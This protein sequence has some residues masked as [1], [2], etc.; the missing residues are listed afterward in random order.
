MT[1]SSPSLVTGLTTSQAISSMFPGPSTPNASLL[2]N[3]LPSMS[4]SEVHYLAAG[5]Y[6]GEGLLTVPAKLAEKITKWEFVD[7]AELLPEFWSLSPKDLGTNTPPRQNNPRCKRA[8]TDIA[9][10]I[11]CFATYV[12]VMSTPHPQSVP[13]LLA[14]LIFILRASQDFRGLAWVTYDAVFRRQAFITGNRLCSKVNP[15][16][17]SI[18]FSGVARTEVRIEL[19]LSLSHPTR[20]VYAGV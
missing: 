5:I 7:M 9:T 2:C 1:A 18:C 13:E 10:W 11:Q 12:S 17:Y 4:Q 15:S 8:I 14:Y 20:R 16:L 19:C 6:M 3:L